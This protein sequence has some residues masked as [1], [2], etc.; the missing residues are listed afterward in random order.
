[1]MGMGMVGSSHTCFIEKNT[2][3]RGNGEKTSILFDF[4]MYYSQQ[5]HYDLNSTNTQT[6]GPRYSKG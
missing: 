4:K 2:F 5:T 6:S 1:M 3:L